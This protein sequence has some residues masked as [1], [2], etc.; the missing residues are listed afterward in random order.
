MSRRFQVKV[1]P[2]M[3]IEE[4]NRRFDCGPYVGGA[5]EAREKIVQLHAP[6]NKLRELTGGIEGIIN[7]GRIP[8]VWVD[9]SN[10]GKAFLQV[11]V[12]A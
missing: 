5:I 9:S 7:A 4:N 3:W 2:I 6:I 10:Y 12:P 11:F 1:V 8:R